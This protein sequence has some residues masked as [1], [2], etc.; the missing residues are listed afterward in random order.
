MDD[1]GHVGI[2]H[3]RQVQQDV[4]HRQEHVVMDQH[5]EVME[6]QVVVSIIDHVVDVRVE[7]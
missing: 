2:I 1:Q 6:M 5:H 4:H 3:Q 7:Q